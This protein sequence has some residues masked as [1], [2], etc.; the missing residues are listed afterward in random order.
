MA[1]VR[2]SWWAKFTAKI[3]WDDQLVGI[4][5]FPQAFRDVE[6]KEIPLFQ[7]PCLKT[8]LLILLDRLNH[9]FLRFRHHLSRRQTRK[10][11][12]GAGSLRGVDGLGETDVVRASKGPHSKT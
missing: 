6:T 3:N 8:D 5:H 11:A 12:S 1:M 10:R 9:P 4:T 7:S 2:L